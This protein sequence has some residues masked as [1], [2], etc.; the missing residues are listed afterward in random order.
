MFSESGLYKILDQLE[1]NSQHAITVSR[2]NLLPERLLVRDNKNRVVISGHRVFVDSSLSESQIHVLS[3]RRTKE[4][5][6]S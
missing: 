5:E 3:M 6:W 4:G 2:L 1:T